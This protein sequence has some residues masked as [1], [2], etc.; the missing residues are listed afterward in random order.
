MQRIYNPINII[1]VSIRDFDDVVSF[2]G[3][4]KSY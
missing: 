3:I 2:Y 1:Q 4:N